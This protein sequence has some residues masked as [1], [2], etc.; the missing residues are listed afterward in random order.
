MAN[1][2]VQWLLFGKLFKKMHCEKVKYVATVGII[3]IL[4]IGYLMY[5]GKWDQPIEYLYLALIAG[6][7]GYLGV[8]YYKLQKHKPINAKT[9]IFFFL[10][11]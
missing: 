9:V 6:I 10:D 1:K 5:T 3:A 7:G 4:Y 11:R 8:I 2:A